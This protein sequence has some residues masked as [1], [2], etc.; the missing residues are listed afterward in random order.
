MPPPPLFPKVADTSVKSLLPFSDSQLQ[1]GKLFLALHPC[2]CLCRFTKRHFFSSFFQLLRRNLALPGG[3][4]MLF[5]QIRDLLL[6][7]LHAE[8]AHAVPSAG[9]VYSNRH[10]KTPA[11]THQSTFSAANELHQ[12]NLS[13]WHHRKAQSQSHSVFL[14]STDSIGRMGELGGILRK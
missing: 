13:E 4:H 8:Q 6:R 7:S 14:H 10:S 9:R 5:L 12:I 3:S 11:N 1:C 2:P